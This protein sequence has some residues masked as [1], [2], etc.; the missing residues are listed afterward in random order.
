[1]LA[2]KKIAGILL[3]AKPGKRRTSYILGIGINC[4]QQ[5]DDFA[6]E[7]QKTATSIDI[8]SR[9]VC[10]RNSIAKSLLSSLA[11]F[12][13]GVFTVGAGSNLCPKELALAGDFGMITAIAMSFIAAVQT[14]RLAS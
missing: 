14:A 11:W 10:D 6:A 2:E 12:S 9:S 1:M 5:K 4:H 3:E 7:L 8:Q 13:A